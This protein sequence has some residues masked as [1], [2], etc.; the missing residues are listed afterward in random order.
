MIYEMLSGMPT[1][2]GADLRQ[3]YQKVL[4][5]DVTFKPEEKFSPRSKELILGLLQRD[6]SKRLGGA[7]NSPKDIMEMS[8]FEGIVWQDIYNRLTDGPWVPSPELGRK[9][10]EVVDMGLERDC[11][12]YFIAFHSLFHSRCR[13]GLT[14]RSD[15]HSRLYHRPKQQK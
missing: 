4:Y 5:A 6:P 7:E 3:T 10:S 11:N 8:F 14:I 13:F 12:F 15:Q 2:R 1:F 9:K